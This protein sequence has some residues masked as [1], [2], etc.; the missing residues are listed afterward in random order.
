[1]SIASKLGVNDVFVSTNEIIDLVQQNGLRFFV[2]PPIRNKPWHRLGVRGQVRMLRIGNISM[3]FDSKV[4]VI[5][6][7]LHK[8]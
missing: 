4:C 7:D 5:I 1:M 8:Y 3:W 6:G 2:L